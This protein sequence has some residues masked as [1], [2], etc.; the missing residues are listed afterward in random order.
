[1]CEYLKIENWKF[2]VKHLEFEI[3]KTKMFEFGC[4]NIEKLKIEN[5]NLKS[6][7]EMF[8][9]NLKVWKLKCVIAKSWDMKCLNIENWKLKCLNTK[10]QTLKCLNNE[11]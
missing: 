2:Y 8:G 11:N 6:L 7:C 1:M 5:K 9:R 3:L 4:V 10:N